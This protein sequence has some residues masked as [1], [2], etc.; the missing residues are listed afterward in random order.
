M[1]VLA[2]MARRGVA[3]DA[4]LGTLRQ[5]GAEMPAA[6]I[7]MLRWAAGRPGLEVRSLPACFAR[8]PLLGTCQKCAFAA[9]NALYH[10]RC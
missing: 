10:M 3:R 4:L 7:D 1:Q 8:L 9:P 2:E 5:M 6:S